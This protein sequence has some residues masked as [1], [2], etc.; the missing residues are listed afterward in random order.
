MKKKHICILI[1]LSAGLNGPLT[2]QPQYYNSDSIPLHGSS[3][4]FNDLTGREN[5]LLYLPGEFNKP[6]PAPAGNIVSISFFIFP[7]NPIGP[8]T[9]TDLTIKM[10]QSNITS[11]TATGF[12]TGPLTT[13]YYKSSVIL[14][15][16]GGQWMTII[17]DTPF[18]YDPTQSLIVDVGQCGVPGATGASM[19]AIY[20]SGWR[21][22]SS[23]NFCPFVWGYTEGLSYDFGITVCL[24]PTISGQSN[25][26][27]NSG[28]SMYLTEPGMTNYTWAVS[29]GGTIISGAG[30]NQV[31]VS[32]FSPGVQTVSVIYANTCGNSPT[33]LNVTVNDL[34]AAAG[35]IT[36][37]AQVCAGQTGVPYWVAPVSG[38]N[39]YLWTLPPDATIASGTGTPNIT[40]DYGLNASSG[41]MSVNANNICGNGVPSPDYWVSVAMAGI[42]ETGIDP[43]ISIYPNPG[44]GLFNLYISTDRQE[45]FTIRIFNSFGAMI[46]ELNDIEVNG[47][48]EKAIDLR[49]A[50]NGIYYF[51]IRN[52]SS[53]IVKKVLLN[54]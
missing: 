50:T 23:W 18:P 7:N 1:L 33:V 10:G 39:I 8:W 52:S 32:W 44:D 42:P 53:W 6:T 3:T 31:W 15:G 27:V 24:V 34:P 19:C 22:T 46:S 49:P 21:R 5:Q 14:T 43:A 13:V 40:V 11:F 45:T 37:S 30:T 41:N 16:P 2:A 25:V 26:C 48:V 38:A 51:V 4:P 35:S 9:Y 17:L 28:Y 29:A 12:Y 47:P 20:L 54:K 36:G